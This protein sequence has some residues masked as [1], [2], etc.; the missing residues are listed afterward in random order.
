MKIK[1]RRGRGFLLL[2]IVT[3]VVGMLLAPKLKTKK[4]QSE[5]GKEK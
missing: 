3:A 4:D 1:K 2:G 5:A